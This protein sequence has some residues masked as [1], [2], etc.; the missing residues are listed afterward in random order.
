MTLNDL[1]V[2]F[3]V[4]SRFNSHA[5]GN[6]ARISTCFVIILHNNWKAHATCNVVFLVLSKEQFFPSSRAYHVTYMYAYSVTVLI[7]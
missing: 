6:T 3:A 2:T 4:H 5:L 1:K 7:I